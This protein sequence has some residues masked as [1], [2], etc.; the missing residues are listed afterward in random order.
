VQEIPKFIH[1][2]PKFANADLLRGRT[3]V[4]AIEYVELWLMSLNVL[5]IQVLIRLDLCDI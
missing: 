2:I 5:D 4:G 1:I 3:I